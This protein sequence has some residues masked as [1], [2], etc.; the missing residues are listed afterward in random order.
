[1]KTKINTIAFMFLFVLL[2]SCAT[3]PSRMEKNT[4]DTFKPLDEASI[5]DGFAVSIASKVNKDSIDVANQ[6][7]L[8]GLDAYRN[9]KDNQQA[10]GLFQ[11]SIFKYPSAKAYYELGNVYLDLKDYDLA[12]S[13][14]KISEQLGYEPFANLLFNIS[15]AYSLTENV[16]MSANYLEYAIQAGYSNFQNIE[17]DVDLL[18]LRKS[19]LFNTH[20]QRAL[21]GVSDKDNIFWLQFKT[22]FP[23]AKLPLKLDQVVHESVLDDVNYI[24]YDYEVYV[25]EMRNERFSR[26]VSRGFYYF[27]RVLETDKYVALVYIDKDMFLNEYSPLNYVL[28][29]FTPTGKIIDK[30]IIA[31]HKYHDEPLKKTQIL[32]DGT[33]S[34][35]NYELTYE[36]D[37]REY[38]FWDNQVKSMAELSKETLKINAN[39]K[40][41]NVGDKIVALN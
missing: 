13:A 35:T 23:Q 14:Y 30:R 5:F 3:G 37:P 21:E 19:V 38:G 15:C 7:F 41:E 8:N 18:N 24:G 34:I 20:Y 32:K 10:I 12:L 6:L 31:G 2:Y 33:I 9:K 22:R 39:G 1:M 29:T 28:A 17:K 25:S 36:N 27:A 16:E 11:S 26:E 4:T 40:I